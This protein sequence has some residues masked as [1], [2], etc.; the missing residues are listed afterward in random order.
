MAI[1]SVALLK[2]S[3]FLLNVSA[4]FVLAWENLKGSVKYWLGEAIT[5]TYDQQS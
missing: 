4:K 3:V 5:F 1:F 2:F